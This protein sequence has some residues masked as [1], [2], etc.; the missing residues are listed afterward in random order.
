MPS[1][2]A[3]CAN[4]SIVIDIKIDIGNMIMDKYMLYNIIPLTTQLMAI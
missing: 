3:S 2:P 1:I 4:S